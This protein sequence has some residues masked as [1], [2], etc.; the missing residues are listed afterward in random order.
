MITLTH[1]CP[2]VHITPESQHLFTLS[3]QGEPYISVATQT[4]LQRLREQIRQRLSDDA[5][6]VTCHPHRI[7]ITSCV[8]IKLEGKCRTINILITVSGQ[9]SWPPEE[10]YTHPRWYITVT[11]TADMLYLVLWLNNVVYQRQNA[12]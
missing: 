11:D 7:G 3:P 10:E 2:A 4:H 1:P 9:E 5:V 6:A 8:A 12:D